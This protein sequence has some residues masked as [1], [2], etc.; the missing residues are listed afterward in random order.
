MALLALASLAIAA[1]FLLEDSFGLE[2]IED[3]SVRVTRWVIPAGSL[4]TSA[5]W[6]LDHDRDGIPDVG[7]SWRQ[8]GQLKIW[9]TMAA[10]SRRYGPTT[11]QIAAISSSTGE[12]LRHRDF[13]YNEEI[14]AHTASDGRIC[15]HRYDDPEPEGTL[16]GSRQC[17]GGFMNRQVLGES[18]GAPV[19]IVIEQGIL[20]VND[21][22]TGEELIREKLGRVSQL[23]SWPSLLESGRVMICYGAPEQWS[24]LSEVLPDGSGR[25]WPF[26]PERHGLPVS[27][28]LRP[29]TGRVLPGGEIDLIAVWQAERT[30]FPL[31]LRL[32]ESLQMQVERL[33]PEREVNGSLAPLVTAWGSFEG[34]HPVFFHLRRALHSPH[35][36]VLD[37]QVSGQT[38]R[39]IQLGIGEA[40]FAGLKAVPGAW[41]GGR[42]LRGIF[43]LDATP[44]PDQNN[45]GQSDWRLLAHIRGFKRHGLVL[46]DLDGATGELLPR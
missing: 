13:P 34:E 42:S 26:R 28:N 45:D 43:H 2:V 38:M 44:I 16:L 30:R 24:E 36:F 25:R 27:G 32:G 21:L 8:P 19:E 9:E 6:A 5:G 3:E 4:H 41:G 11:A 14:V 31:R 29:V 20:I 7:I 23:F 46:I 37:T 40:D 10:M 35:Q 22:T 39:T 17:L 12:I 33:G 15:L 1:R 18:I